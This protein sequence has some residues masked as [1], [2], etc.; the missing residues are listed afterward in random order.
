MPDFDEKE[1]E[2]AKKVAIAHYKLIT[3]NKQD[4]W[5]KTMEPRKKHDALRYYWQLTL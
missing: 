3:E 1:V 4:D 2:A 5:L